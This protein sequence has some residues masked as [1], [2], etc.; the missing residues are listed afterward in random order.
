MKQDGLGWQG[1]MN[2]MLREA[3]GL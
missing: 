2:D 1:R 3:V